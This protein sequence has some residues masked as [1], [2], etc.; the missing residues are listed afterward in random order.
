MNERLAAVLA[1][2]FDIRKADVH[3]GLAREDVGSWDSLR[4]M[5]LVVS[6]EREYG[7]ALDITDMVQMLSVAGIIKVLQQKGVD[8]GD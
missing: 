3:L 5:D 2:V 8:L 6:L 1:E 7:I 4:Q